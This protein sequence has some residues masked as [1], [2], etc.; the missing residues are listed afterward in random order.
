[1]SDEPETDPAIET[2]VPD[3]L[4][5]SGA[6]FE[7]SKGIHLLNEVDVPPD[8]LPPS[9]AVTAHPPVEAAPREP[10]SPPVPDTDD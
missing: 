3:S 1:M 5:G 4:V 9:A 8:V 6:Q 10:S 2:A 7:R